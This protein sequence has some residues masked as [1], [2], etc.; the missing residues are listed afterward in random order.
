MLE[1]PA[2]LGRRRARN[3]PGRAPQNA[4]RGPRERGDRPVL[5]A[6]VGAAGL[7]P[8][9][10]LALGV[11]VTSPAP[12]CFGQRPVS[13]RIRGEPGERVAP[14]PGAQV[15]RAGGPR[16]A[17]AR[18]G[19]AGKTCGLPTVLSPFRL[20]SLLPRGELSGSRRG[21]RGAGD[22]AW[23]GTIRR[24]PQ[25]EGRRFKPA[26]PQLG[27]RLRALLPFGRRWDPRD[28]APA[29]TWRWKVGRVFE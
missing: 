3:P 27:R 11:G 12:D 4:E 5:Q 8:P 21:P 14:A 6:G 1:S 9:P 19:R 17:P 10:A 28:A 24:R 29:G 20:Q 16:Q 7:E 2:G 26:T 15:G 18:R 25:S 23:K 13:R 22:P